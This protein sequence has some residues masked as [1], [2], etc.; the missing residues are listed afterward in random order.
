MPGQGE[1][2]TAPSAANGAI[3]PRCPRCGYDQSGAVATWTDA[4][5]LK[6][7]CPE[8]GWEF[9]VCDAMNPR[10]TDLPW[11]HEHTPGRGLGVGRALR[12]LVRALFPWW[13]WTCVGLACRVSVVRLVL[14]A[15]LLFGGVHAAGAAVRTYHNLTWVS[16][17][18]VNVSPEFVWT[19]IVNA[20]LTPFARAQWNGPWNW[21]ITPTLGFWGWQALAAVAPL[22]LVPVMLLLLG[23]SRAVTRVR[24]GHIARAAVMQLTVFIVPATLFALTA[25][26]QSPTALAAYYQPF[27]DLLRQWGGFVMA[28]CGLWW[29]AFWYFAIVRGYRL[30]RGRLIWALLMVASAL[31]GAIAATLDQRFGLL[32]Q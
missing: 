11:L 20:W 15:L 17:L 27:S 6:A 12:T 2:S 30:P 10:R 25:L 21:S 9:A 29:M 13:Y 32:L 5:P 22:P 14:W 16:S 18:K 28:G 3:T 7:T 19:G 4:C 23:S 8:C 24:F 31:L 1:S 26:E